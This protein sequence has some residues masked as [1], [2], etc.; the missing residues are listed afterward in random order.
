MRAEYV[1][2]RISALQCSDGILSN[3]QTVVCRCI[4]GELG[5][6]R[7]MC[8]AAMCLLLSGCGETAYKFGAGTD[9]FRIAQKSCLE[10]RIDEAAYKA[11]MKQK[12]WTV[13]GIEGSV[14]GTPAEGMAAAPEAAAEPAASPSTPSSAPVPA[15]TAPKPASSSTSAAKNEVGG[16]PAPKAPSTP[17][18]A[19]AKAL[20][21]NEVVT[22]QSW[23]K[24]G[25][26]D[27]KTDIH[28]CQDLLGG[29][30]RYDEVKKT[31]TRAV[32]GCMRAKGWRA[33]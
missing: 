26:T 19:P 22:V 31:A 2:L 20:D 17:T 18:Q 21:P 1:K 28:A 3:T 33:Y 25:A 16:A 10:N 32:V 8:I 6:M 5:M 29:I 11:C 13:I 4:Y 12:G 7:T 24:V 27:F 15:T 23:W 9:E 14:V 30:H